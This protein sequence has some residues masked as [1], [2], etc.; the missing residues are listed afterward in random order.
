[1]K[2]CGGR[3]GVYALLA[4]L[5]CLQLIYTTWMFAGKQVFHSDEF[6]SYGLANSYYQ[7]FIYMR[8]GVYI[9]DCTTE[10]LIN[11]DE[12]VPGETFQRYL[13]VQEGERFAYAS[14]Y[15]NQTLDHHPP[16]YYALLHTICSLFPD[17]F[18]MW[19]GFWLNLVFLAGTQIFLYLLAVKVMGN[20][21]KALLCCFLY[22]VGNGALLTFTFV[23]QYS[24]LTML[25]MGFTYFCACVYEDCQNGAP[26]RKHLAETA[27]IAFCAFMTHYYAIIYV[28][29][30][31]ACFCLWLLCA[32]RWK[33]CLQFGFCMA[34][35]LG[36]FLLSFPA[37]LM[38]ALSNDAQKTRWSL[39]I[40]YKMILNY[41]L[42]YNLGVAVEPWATPFFQILWPCLLFVLLCLLL[43]FIPFRRE[44]WMGRL[45]L[46]MRGIPVR[47]AA[48]IKPENLRRGN[49]MACFCLIAI[50]VQ[51][52]AVNFTCSVLQMGAYS[53]RYVFMGF[54]LLCFAVVS[55]AN[56]F[57]SGIFRGRKSKVS[58]PA[59]VL[60]TLLAAVS[61]RIRTTP[62]L[63]QHQPGEYRDLAELLRDKNCLFLPGSPKESWLLTNLC[64]YVRYAGGVFTTFG[65][66]LK[67]Y[68]EELYGDGSVVDYVLVYGGCLELDEAEQEM[69][70]AWFGDQVRIED[71]VQVEGSAEFIKEASDEEELQWLNQE[72]CSL[73]GGCEYEILFGVDL[74]GRV[75]YVLKLR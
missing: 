32:G 72:I 22:G 50:L 43:L 71:S 33:R 58:F 8:D 67:E 49:F 26:W 51:C 45:L 10:D 14:V 19:Y 15:H 38:Q 69:T 73:N 1:M 27:L 44:A 37:C 30:F 47:L 35:V 52:L 75:F 24:L 20:P 68:P 13:T 63:I 5:I 21:W 18:S 56:R 29:A 55:L 46:W 23:R 61:A 28:G 39:R 25:C 12:W 53:M 48:R 9:G 40:Q 11:F 70:A 42:E 3:G 2:K 57:L 64:P 4:A 34:G 31:T 6:W 17:H 65:D 66:K 59:L 36:L 41:I 7:P 74:N 60:L 62:L 54:P 16:L